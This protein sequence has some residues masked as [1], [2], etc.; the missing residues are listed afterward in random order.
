V[1]GFDLAD[2][3]SGSPPKKHIEAFNMM[4]EK[5]TGVTIHAGRP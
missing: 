3:E 4:R 1:V 5:S 2:L